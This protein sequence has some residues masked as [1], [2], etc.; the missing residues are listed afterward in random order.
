MLLEDHSLVEL[1]RCV[2]DTNGMGE[3]FLSIF[4]ASQWMDTYS[5]E[6]VARFY[7]DTR[8]HISE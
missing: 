3:R 2:V 6:T 8:R 7:Q 1:W 4:N 5:S